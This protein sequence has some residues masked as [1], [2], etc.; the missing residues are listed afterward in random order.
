MRLISIVVALELV[1]RFAHA[2]ASAEQVARCAAVPV[3]AL[4]LQCYDALAK[5]KSDSARSS[6][7]TVSASAKMIGNW[8]MSVEKDPIT[9]QKGVT[10]LLK[11]D[12]ENGFNP[13]TLII[14]CKRGELDA[15]LAT[16]EYLGDG[17]DRVTIRFGNEQAMEEV[18]TTSS[19]H[20][21]LFHPGDRGEV[22]EFVRKLAQYGRVAFQVTPYEKGPVA[23][24]FSVA[25][26]GKVNQ[27]LWAICPPQQSDPGASSG[28]RVERDEMVT[29]E[30][31]FMEAVVEEKPALLS[32]PTLQ[33]PELLRQAQI[34]G[35]VLVQAIIDTL[36]RAEPNSVKV[37]QSPNPGFDQS[38]TTYVL[39][40][41]FRPAR[42]H[43]RAVRVLIQIPVDF[44]LNKWK[45]S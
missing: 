43:G 41:L 19:N 21:A 40:A 12:G 15:F 6:P 18:W 13:P 45:R 26:I 37:L 7:R 36:G 31:V 14:R 17:N 8:A 38:A 27:E 23:M 22:E 4:R 30:E 10:F 34:Q 1:A 28:A 29:T 25:G 20:T 33:F 39:A 44:K 2:Q 3:A 11:A 42:V 24:V 35:R 5:P 9:D 32:G 16:S